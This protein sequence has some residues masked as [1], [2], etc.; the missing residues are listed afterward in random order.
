MNRVLNLLLLLV[1]SLPLQGRLACG[2]NTAIAIG[3]GTVPLNGP[4]RFRTS[5]DLRWA[6]PN[7]DDAGW[8]IVDLTPAPGARDNDVGLPGYVSGWHA[9]GHA[10][11]YGFAWYRLRLT[12]TGGGATLAVAGPFAADS[13]YQLYANGRLL[14]G[15]GDF[16]GS[17][18]TAYSPHRPAWF[19]L[20]P[21]MQAG[22]PLALAVRVW[23][24]PWARSSNEGGM[25]IAPTIGASSAI[26]D[27][28][29]LQWLTIFEGYAV[30][31]VE[32][33][34][35]L[36]LT[37]FALSLRGLEPTG[38]AYAWLAA[39]LFFLA[40]Q[41]GNQAVMFLGHFETIPE[42]ELFIIVLAI[43]LYMG[44][45]IM[46]WRAWLKLQTPRWVPRAVAALT[47]LYML[48][49]FL[50][51]SWF[52]GVLPEQAFTV[53]YDVTICV[54]YALL[55]LYALTAYQ[56][57]RYRG[58]HGWCALVVMAALGIGLYGSEFRYFGTAGIWFPFGVGVSLSEISI[59]AFAPL[60][61]VL[62]VRRFWACARE[63]RDNAHDDLTP[64][65]L[66]KPVI[67]VPP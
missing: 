37:L 40:I 30:D 49:V 12:V 4:W 54:R 19:T 41:R 23:L 8:E 34:V 18:P 9:R 17:T 29:R 14:G 66:V 43:P 36:L 55:L 35:L 15:V 63:Q 33:L 52:R 39:A 44:C 21:E 64:V 3:S 2:E 6:D 24:G 62:I 58:R 57:A 42:F 1:L 65:D 31:A 56:G 32:G 5:D 51:R 38:H 50:R 45:W 11:Y 22:A 27:Q 53:A 7:F 59:A 13:A 20:P 16:R 25:H 48:S 46:A 26:A 47:L 67:D 10:D 61:A 60:M 28:Y